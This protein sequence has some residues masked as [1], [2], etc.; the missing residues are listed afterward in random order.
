MVRAVGTGGKIVGVA[1]G[2]MIVGGVVGGCG[3]GSGSSPS[4]AAVPVDSVSS[5]SAMQPASGSASDTGSSGTRVGAGVGVDHVVDGDTFALTDGHEVRVLGIDSCELNTPGGRTAK[6][7]AEV[8]LSMGS[9]TIQSQ[10]GVDTDRYGRLLRYVE[11]GNGTDFGLSMVGTSHTGVYGGRNDASPE[12]VA[13]LRDADHD[14]RDCSVGPAE[15][16]TRTTTITVDP[17]RDDDHHRYL[18]YVDPSPVDQ[19]HSDAPTRSHT[20]HS[21]HPCL[22][23]ER[24]GDH[25]GYCGEG[26]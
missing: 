22:P 16:T 7:D 23:G 12:R 1:L 21:G 13:Q 14:G 8:L 25:D 19:P 3:S 20:G 4:G 2:V 24:D 5:V 11:I 26:K 9:V 10:P 18:P 15:P 17:P 6:R